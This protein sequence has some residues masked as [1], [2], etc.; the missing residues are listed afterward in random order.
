MKEEIL[1]HK[2]VNS[3]VETWGTLI[4]LRNGRDGVERRQ[5]FLARDGTTCVPSEKI[6]ESEEG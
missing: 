2:V 4:W 1:K 6:G 3:L 5:R